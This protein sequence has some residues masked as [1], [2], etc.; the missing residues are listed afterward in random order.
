MDRRQIGKVLKVIAIMVTVVLA[1]LLAFFFWTE[2][3]EKKEMQAAY[4]AMQ[5]E[6]RPLE[7]EI[8]ELQQELNGIKEEDDRETRGTGSIVLL[9]TDLSE[10]IYTDAYPQMA[11]YGF[12]GVL[13]LGEGQ[14]LGE[15][16]YLK[17]EQLKELLAA[18]WECCL[19][20]EEGMNEKKWPAYSRRLVRRAKI[21][22]P[23]SVYFQQEAYDGELDDFLKEQHFSVAVHHGEGD[24]ALIAAE[25]EE[26]LWHFG[27][28]AWNGNDSSSMLEETMAQRGN[29]IFTIGS[30][31]PEEEY[32]KDVCEAMLGRIHEYCE[33]DEL[34]VM[35]LSEAAEYREML[36]DKQNGTMETE[37]SRKR[38]ELEERIEELNQEI[39]DIT[40][41]YRKGK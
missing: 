6:I 30:D 4:E 1:A 40:E 18:G 38:A 33:A 29:L 19:K 10:G 7:L 25:A 32:Q 24:I 12:K 22:S 16:G 41:K 5:N 34:Q 15:E 17:E 3:K 36:K 21:E 31:S 2:N 13:A 26:E 20:W 9:F 39:D 14:V 23:K 37:I 11:K 28:L 8:Y 27:A 35:T